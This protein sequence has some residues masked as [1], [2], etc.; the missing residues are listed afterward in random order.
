[1]LV[2]EEFELFDHL[3]TCFFTFYSIFGLYAQ[4]PVL[5]FWIDHYGSQSF[6]YAVFADCYDILLDWRVH[7]YLVNVVV[8]AIQLA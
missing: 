6:N 3:L 2:I 4:F 1:M 5:N 7:D 8:S